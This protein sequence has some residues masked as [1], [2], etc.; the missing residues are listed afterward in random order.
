[1]RGLLPPAFGR[2]PGRG[3]FGQHRLYSR[4]QVI[5]AAM[6]VLEADLM[7]KRPQRWTSP[8][9]PPQSTS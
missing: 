5:T 8:V 6:A 9:V 1:M 7:F 3:K 4:E 2:T